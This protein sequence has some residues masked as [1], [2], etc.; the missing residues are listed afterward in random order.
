VRL[1]P[2]TH[3]NLHCETERQARTVLAAITRRMAHVGLGLHPDKTRIVYCKDSNRAG[4]H[5]H[6]R[7]DFLGYTYRP[8]LAVGR[9][10]ELF[11]SFCPAVSDDAA[12]AIRQQI[13]RWRLHLRSG[14]TLTELAQEINPIVRGWINYYGHFYRS[15]LIRSLRRIDDF[16]V[17]WAMRKY[18]R[19]RGKL[20]RA[21]D[22]LHAVQR[23][24][25]QLLAH[26]RSRSLRLDDTSPVS[27][28]GHAGF[29]ERRGA[30][31]P[32][33]TQPP[34]LHG[35]PTP[36]RRGGFSCGPRDRRRRRRFGSARACLWG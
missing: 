29:C 36:A 31:L 10:G 7:F 13:K 12:K 22:L 6:E 17:R 18:K 32:P 1:P 33:A 27:R 8:R 34:C 14:Q 16:L 21:W 26:W 11:T 24:Q 30:R 19:L 5:E 15:W 28:E 4:S 2:A 3:L 9:R 20:S 25:P 23:R 35:V